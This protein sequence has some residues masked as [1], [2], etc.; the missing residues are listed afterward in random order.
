M[1]ELRSYRRRPDQYVVAVPLRLETQGLTYRKW[2]AEQHGKPGDWLVDNDGDI[3]TVDADVFTATYR[4]IR[5]GAYVK[6]APVWAEVARESGSVATKEGR[7][8]YNSGDY[9]VYNNEDGTDGYA[10]SA[11]KFESHY[12][13]DD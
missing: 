12:E 7:T 11:E 2:G 1:S 4:Q 13:P 8:H 10:M 3:Y 5:R 6:S 9:L